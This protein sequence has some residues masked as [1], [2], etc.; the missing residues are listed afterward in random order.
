MKMC[1]AKIWNTGWEENINSPYLAL[2]S[3]Y[4]LRLSISWELTFS[5]SSSSRRKRSFALDF[6]SH[7]PP[8]SRLFSFLFLSQE[9][10]KKRVKPRNGEVR[11]DIGR[12]QNCGQNSLPLPSYRSPL[13]PPSRQPRWRLPPPGRGRR[14]LRRKQGSEQSDGGIFWCKSGFETGDGRKRFHSIF[15]L[16][17]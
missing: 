14:W 4:F 8:L 11:R 13:L 15:C 16:I 2:T 6:P 1:K 10:S 5:T 3:H 7:L 17:D 9:S 12:L